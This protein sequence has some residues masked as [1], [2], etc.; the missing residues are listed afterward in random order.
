MAQ[1]NIPKAKKGDII[2]YDWSGDGTIDHLAIV[3]G[4]AGNNPQYPLVAEWGVYG[5]KSVNYNERGW[6]WSKKGNSWL[7]DER[8]QHNMKAYLLHFRSDDDL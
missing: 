5:S 3:V 8:D 2:A 7:Q 1:S 6:S 4:S